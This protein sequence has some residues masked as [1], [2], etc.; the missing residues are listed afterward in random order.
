VT[1]EELA[2]SGD[3]LIYLQ[4]RERY[5]QGPHK[6]VPAEAVVA[7]AADPAHPWHNR[8]EWDD[9]AAARLYRLEQARHILRTIKITVQAR[10][11]SR[12]RVRAAVFLPSQ[13]GYVHTP[14]VLR[15]SD[16]RAEMLV[17]A[18][19]ELSALRAKY[20]VLTELAD[21]WDLIDTHPRIR[22]ATAAENP[23]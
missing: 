8:F 4:L 19:K 21:V 6:A 7:E 20:A 10:P 14:Q 9:T 23:G 11:D 12:V 3:E 22:V 5:G 2:P 16:L 1:E 15:E 17:Q 18:A 13:S